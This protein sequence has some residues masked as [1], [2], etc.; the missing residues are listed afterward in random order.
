MIVGLRPAGFFV[1]TTAL[2][3]FGIMCLCYF[4]SQYAANRT[5]ADLHLSLIS[6]FDRLTTSRAGYAAAASI[7]VIGWF[8]LTGGKKV[9]VLASSPLPGRA[10]CWRSTGPLVSNGRSTDSSGWPKV[11][12]WPTSIWGTG[13]GYLADSA[14]RC[15]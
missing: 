10:A 12:Y 8:A 4:Y 3:V 7:L 9:T 11:D 14:R 13:H 5:Q 15:K 6:L 1:N 2:A